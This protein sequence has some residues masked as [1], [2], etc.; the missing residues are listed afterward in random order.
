MILVRPNLDN[1]PAAPLFPGYSIW[2]AVSHDMPTVAM[3]LNHCLPNGV[4]SADRLSKERLSGAGFAYL[5]L[6]GNR[7]VGCAFGGEL[8]GMGS[9]DLVAVWPDDRRL[10]IG[11]SLVW[12]CLTQHRRRGHTRA[13]LLIPEAS[14]DARRFADELGFVDPQ[15][16]PPC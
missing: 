12:R 13:C 8:L 9:V 3:L 10:G 1:V 16:I 2:E 7:T 6:H 11:S 14:W 15:E 4:L 5:A